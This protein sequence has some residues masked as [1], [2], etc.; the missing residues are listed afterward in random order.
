MVYLIACKLPLQVFFLNYKKLI[1]FSP[2]CKKIKAMNLIGAKKEAC[3]HSNVHTGGPQ[4][5]TILFNVTAALLQCP[6]DYLIK[7]WPFDVYL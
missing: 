5:T 7:I 6:H 1:L 3:D 2:N 4:L